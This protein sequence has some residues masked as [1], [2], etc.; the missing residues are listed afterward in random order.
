[1]GLV[2][3]AYASGLLEH[4]LQL[5]LGL[6]SWAVAAPRAMVGM[7][8]HTVDMVEGG[9]AAIVWRS[10]ARPAGRRLRS[11]GMQTDGCVPE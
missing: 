7:L 4:A 1:M 5:V 11:Q 8:A 6:W 10:L 2:A 9:L 3:V